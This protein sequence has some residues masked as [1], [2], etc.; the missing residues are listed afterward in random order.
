MRVLR[1]M[2][3]S[4]SSH[5][6][7]RALSLLSQRFI[8]RMGVVCRAVVESHRAVGIQASSLRSL[9]RAYLPTRT[10]FP[11]CSHVTSSVKIHTLPV[12]MIGPGIAPGKATFSFLR[13]LYTPLTMHTARRPGC[14][15]RSNRHVPYRS[16]LCPTRLLRAPVGIAEI[17]PLVRGISC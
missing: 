8:G 10:Y 11:A 7:S 16:S 5:L 6:S 9:N 12:S 14:L 3:F 2:L 15:D 4:S 13:R 1:F 17:G